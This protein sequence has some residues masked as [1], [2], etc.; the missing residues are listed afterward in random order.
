MSALKERVPQRP[1]PPA[2]LQAIC[3]EV[4]TAQKQQAL[5]QLLEQASPSLLTLPLGLE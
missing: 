1:L 4:D 3:E 5:L 2:L